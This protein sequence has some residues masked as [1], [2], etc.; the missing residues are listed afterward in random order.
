MKYC[1]IDKA[2]S[3]NS[4]QPPQLHVTSHQVQSLNIFRQKSGSVQLDSDWKLNIAERVLP[5]LLNMLQFTES[6]NP[7]RI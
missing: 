7:I 2:V 1:D 5:L 4:K 3:G 6:H